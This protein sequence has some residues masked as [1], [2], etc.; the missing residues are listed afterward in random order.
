M[1]KTGVVRDKRYLDHNMGELHPESPARL[2]GIYDMLEDID[3]KGNFIDVPSIYAQRDEL[4]YIHSP[5]YIDL[6]AETSG[7]D[8]TYLDPDTQTSAG[9]YE[10][11]L[12]AAGGLCEAISLVHSKGL[13]NAFALVRPPGHHAEQNR[14]MGFCLFN[15]VAIGAAYARKKLGLDR[16]LVID[17]DLHHGNGT[18]HSFYDDP[19]VLYI[20]THQYPHYPGTGAYNEFGSGRGEGFTLNVP[21]SMGY[22]DSEFIDIFERLIRPVTCEYQPEMILVSAGFDTHTDDPLGGMKVTPHGFAGMTRSI[23]NMATDCCDGKVVMTL[24]GGYNIQGLKDSVKIV[25][26]ELAGLSKTDISNLSAEADDRMVDRAVGPVT[27][28]HKRYWQNL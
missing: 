17:W 4:L 12:L 9:S 6:L 23:M 7:K 15:N 10:A 28:I 25:L 16:I 1:N 5:E 21:L 2:E 18:Q 3:M 27:E 11:A 8:N 14:A 13:N 26:K 19:S 20:S 22:G 24:E